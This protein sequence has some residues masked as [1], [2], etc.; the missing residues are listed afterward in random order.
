MAPENAQSGVEDYDVVKDANETIAEDTRKKFDAYEH[1]I[2]EAVCECNYHKAIENCLGANKLLHWWAK[3]D[4]GLY[5][6]Y[7]FHV[8]VWEDGRFKVWQDINEP[9]SEEVDFLDVRR[10]NGKS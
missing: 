7:R 4:T 2:T 8:R 10:M 3:E 6:K 5:D 1:E 9:Q